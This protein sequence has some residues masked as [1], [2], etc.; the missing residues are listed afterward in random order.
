MSV[1][2]FTTSPTRSAA[3]AMPPTL[4]SVTLARSAA[5]LAACVARPTCWLIS[6]MLDDIS[7]AAAATAP[8]LVADVVAPSAARAAL[9]RVR[10]AAS[11]IS[12][13]V[14][15]IASAERARLAITPAAE[16]PKSCV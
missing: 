1:I 5:A 8:R 3:A 10:C 4:V 7:S 14:L 11:D 13:A 6:L 2:S 12:A 15:R 16:V 9:S